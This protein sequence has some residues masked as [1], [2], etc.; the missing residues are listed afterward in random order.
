MIA[1]HPPVTV[2]PP[3]TLSAA[4]LV[5]LKRGRTISV[6]LPA[7]NEDATI[8]P[9]VTAIRRT[10]MAPK[11]PPLVDELIVLDDGSTDATALVAARSGAD[12]VNVSDVLSETGPGRGKGNVLWKSLAASTG[13]LVVWCDTDLTSFTPNYVTR[14]VAPLLQ[15]EHVELVKGFYDRPLD[16]AGHGGGRTTELVARPL[17]SMFF[18]PLASV[19]QPLGG[20]CAGRRRLLERLPFVEG[21]GVETGL[22]ID[23]LRLVGTRHLAQVDLGTRTHRHRTLLQL[24][25]QSAEITAVVLLRAGIEL[26]RPLPPLVRADGDASPVRVTER[27]PMIEVVGYQR[28]EPDDARGLATA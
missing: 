6:C 15:D 3:T 10:L 23:A 14:L 7:R 18:P 4:D 19:R 24:A 11:G 16:D 9:I 13:D 28:G 5:R 8:G 25:E 20:E 1:V 12:V 17:L 22:L 21:Y 26:P 2:V 27:P